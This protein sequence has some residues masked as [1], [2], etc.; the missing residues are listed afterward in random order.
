[1]YVRLQFFQNVE[2]WLDECQ[3]KQKPSDTS[4]TEEALTNHKQ[5]RESCDALHSTVQ[6]DGKKLVE[7]LRRPVGDSSLPTGFVMGTRHVK[8][9]LENLYDE[10]SWIDEQ[11]GKRQ[12]MLTRTLNLCKF[13]DQAKEVGLNRS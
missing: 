3:S 6:Q 12:T 5:L 7:K 4:Q 11:W 2:A 8:E 9:I 10:R 1:M 13:Q